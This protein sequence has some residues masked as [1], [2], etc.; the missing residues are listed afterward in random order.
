[1][2]IAILQWAWMQDK[3]VNKRVSL[4]VFNEKY[5]YLWALRCVTLL[6]GLAAQM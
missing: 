6:Y 3:S 5:V 1:M 2:V 4:W